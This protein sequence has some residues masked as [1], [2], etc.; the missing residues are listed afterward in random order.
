MRGSVPSINASRYK[1]CEHRN[2]IMEIVPDTL[3]KISVHG[4]TSEQIGA[5]E[6]EVSSALRKR[7]ENKLPGLIIHTVK[8]NLS[9]AYVVAAVHW[10]PFAIPGDLPNSTDDERAECEVHF[11][12]NKNAGDPE[13]AEWVWKTENLKNI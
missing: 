6:R 8:Y 7:L 5:V 13:R 4:R 3:E 12:F 9:M 10:T 11:H 1:L 2:F